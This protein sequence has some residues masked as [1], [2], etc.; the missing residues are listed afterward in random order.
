MGAAAALVAY[1]A[2]VVW[3]TWPLAAHATTHLVNTGTICRTDIPYITWAL[4]WQSHALATAPA[5][6]LDTNIYWPAH[7]TLFYGDPGLGALPYFAPVFLATG[8][9]TLAVNC[10]FLLGII[11]TAWS[12]HLVVQRW[13]GSHAAGVVA[14][15]TLLMN[16][17]VI[18][19]FFPWAPSYTVFFYLPW[20]A[21]LAATPARRLRD[22]LWLVPLLVLQCLGNMVY[23][24]AATLAPLALLAL[25][26]IVRPATRHAGVRLAVA[27][28]IT[29]VVLAPVY[30][31]YLDAR[32]SSGDIRA[33]SLW[34]TTREDLPPEVEARVVRIGGVL[35]P[36]VRVPQDIT[37]V[38]RSTWVSITTLA[39]IA[40]GALLAGWRAF[41]TTAWVHGA[42]WTSVGIVLSIPAASFFGGPGHAMPHYQLLARVV[43]IANEVIR[44]PSRLGMTCLVGWAVLAGVA[45]AACATRAGPRATP[46]LLMLVLAGMYLQFRAHTRA[47][48]PLAEAIDGRSAVTRAL[49]DGSG[50]VLELPVG[51]RGIQALAHARAMYRSIFH[52]RPLLNG[53]SSFWPDG[54]PAR[55]ELAQRVPETDALAALRRETGL[56]SVVVD[57]HRL[58]P[59]ARRIWE[60]IASEGRRDLRL[61]VRDG[62]ELLFE[63]RSPGA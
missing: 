54:F 35:R 27:L 51:A 15:A 17:W 38:T 33:E 11:M 41:R 23:V 50:P 14:A 34:S 56:T 13:T 4:S 49:R 31:G 57:L 28:G 62:D 12:L 42:L 5:T 55:M 52:W 32:R 20:I 6:V 59:Q 7:R 58:A 18:W 60:G 40:T 44:E 45:F 53:Y 25:G 1:A 8:N 22:A 30:A 16:P 10:L 36:V 24:T 9:P 43:P 61:I 29:V 63:V 19:G 47:E 46:F 37:A 21:Y 48:Y 2:V 3:E 39:L 26:R